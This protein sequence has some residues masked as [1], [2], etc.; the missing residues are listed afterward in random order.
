MKAAYIEDHFLKSSSLMSLL[1]LHEPLSAINFK[2]YS[3]I[4]Q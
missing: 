1:Y 4:A 3:Q 2:L